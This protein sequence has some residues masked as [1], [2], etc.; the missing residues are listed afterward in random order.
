MLDVLAN[1]SGVIGGV[2][3]LT[4][5]YKWIKQK[6]QK[7]GT[8][9]WTLPH[10]W[11]AFSKNRTPHVNIAFFKN[12]MVSEDDV[13]SIISDALY[14]GR[15][16][17]TPACLIMIK[18]LPDCEHRLAKLNKSRKL[19]EE[20]KRLR[21]ALHDTMTTLK[22][23]QDLMQRAV[24][25][26]FQPD[27][28]RMLDTSYMTFEGW[29]SCLLGFFKIIKSSCMVEPRTTKIDVWREK[30]PKL[31]APIWVTQEELHEIMKR[32]GVSSPQ[33]LAMGPGSFTAMQL[34]STVLTGKVVPSVLFEI[35]NN[36]DKLDQQHI[37][38]LFQIAEWDIGLG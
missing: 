19:T 9:F 37:P 20:E 26:L 15:Q 1:I 35:T 23:K 16:G 32:C 6:L 22:R 14:Y 29:H 13:A 5:F 3:T 4:I 31:S 2:A 34:P 12:P 36:T 28:I 10:R 30:A 25:I 7:T 38:S 8:K 11:F 18:E 17:Q 24:N 27:V 33:H 21:I